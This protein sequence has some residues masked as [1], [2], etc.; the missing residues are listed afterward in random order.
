MLFFNIASLYF[1]TL[2]NWYINLIIDGTIYPSQHFSFG[3]AIV[4]QAGNFWT[5]LRVY[6]YIHCLNFKTLQLVDLNYCWLCMVTWEWRHIL[7]CQ[8][9]RQ[10]R[11]IVR[12]VFKVPRF[13]SKWRR[14]TENWQL[15]LRNYS[16]SNDKLTKAPL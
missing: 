7:W 10:K 15:L 13:S 14:A 16:H 8:T 12:V 5:L 3:A 1:K 11:Q 9:V 2:F 4:C 6:I